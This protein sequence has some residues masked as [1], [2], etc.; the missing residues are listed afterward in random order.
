V[1]QC[2]EARQ[3]TEKLFYA[4]D[5]FFGRQ[6]TIVPEYIK[7]YKGNLREFII[8]NNEVISDHHSIEELKKILKAK[9]EGVK[10]KKIVKGFTAYT[11]KAEGVVR[12]IFS[13]K[14]YGKIKKGDILVAVNT[15]PDYSLIIKKAAAIVVDEGGLLCHA[16]IIAREMKKPCIVGTKTAT[17]AFKDGD[18]V[19]VD[20]GRGTIRKIGK[21]RR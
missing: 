7:K 17:S 12:V 18:I 10:N 19:E 14:D 3:K 20:A 5:T 13:R 2:Q 9:N 4:V 8:F 1:A 16:A 21:A 11:G 6:K 15:S